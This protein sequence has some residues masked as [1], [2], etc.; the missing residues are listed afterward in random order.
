MVSDKQHKLTWARE[1]AK[2]EHLYK[3]P[4]EVRVKCQTPGCPERFCFCETSKYNVGHD[5]ARSDA[6]ENM[7]HNLLI[8]CTE[9]NNKMGTMTFD[10]WVVS[11]KRVRPPD[12]PHHNFRGVYP[13]VYGRMAKKVLGDYLQERYDTPCVGCEQETNQRSLWC[14]G[15]QG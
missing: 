7:E 2:W 14:E 3:H 11:L 5:V 8:L 1:Q 13:G 4:E 9:C 12:H 10:E 15:K 6:G